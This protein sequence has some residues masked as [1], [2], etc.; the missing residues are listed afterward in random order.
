MAG[1]LNGGAVLHSLEGDLPVVPAV[2]EDCVGGCV[3]VE[4]Y[5]DGECGGVYET[6]C[7]SWGARGVRGE[8]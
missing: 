6:H 8:R 2:G 7:A 5:F 1:L 3:A 4:K